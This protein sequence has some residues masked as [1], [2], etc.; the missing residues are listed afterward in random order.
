[1]EER[2]K[3]TLHQVIQEEYQQKKLGVWIVFSPNV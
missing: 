3:D 2:I 1:M